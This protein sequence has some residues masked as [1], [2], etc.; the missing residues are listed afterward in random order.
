MNAV[1]CFSNNGLIADTKR[2]GKYRIEIRLNGPFLKGR[3][4]INCTMAG[5]DIRQPH[6]NTRFQR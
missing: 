2:L 1:R 4:R 6:C 5:N 3:G